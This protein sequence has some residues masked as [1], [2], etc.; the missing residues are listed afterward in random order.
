MVSGPVWK[1]KSGTGPQATTFR[2]LA[3][4]IIALLSAALNFKSVKERS[5]HSLSEQKLWC[6]QTNPT[7]NFVVDPM[8]S[9]KFLP[10]FNQLLACGVIDKWQ[11]RV[12]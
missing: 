12:T 5:S 9:G 10:T 2:S 6:K 1:S 3:R 8:Q 4:S 7:F 11:M